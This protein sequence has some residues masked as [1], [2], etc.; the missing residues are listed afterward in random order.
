VNMIERGGWMDG[1][2]NDGVTIH[3]WGKNFYEH[4]YL[5]NK[6]GMREKG[7]REKT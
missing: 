5:Y 6:A 7:E 4:F 1:W 2:M 3:N